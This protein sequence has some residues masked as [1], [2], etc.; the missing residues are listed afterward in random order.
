MKTPS[1]PTAAGRCVAYCAAFLGIHTT[2]TLAGKMPADA[3]PQQ[4]AAVLIGLGTRY[5]NEGNLAVGLAHAY[6]LSIDRASALMRGEPDPVTPAASNE[7]APEPVASSWAKVRETNAAA[8]AAAAA[9]ADIGHEAAAPPPT[10]ISSADRGRIAR[11]WAAARAVNARE[12]HDA[13]SDG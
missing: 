7:T 1:L 8:N 13:D 10:P 2:E 6:G 12:A 9:A 3:T 4:A 11:D 5:P